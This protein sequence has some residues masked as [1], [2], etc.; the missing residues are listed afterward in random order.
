MSPQLPDGVRHVEIDLP[1]GRRE[2]VT[3]LVRALGLD[4]LLGLEAGA[5]GTG[6]DALA[7]ALSEL[8]AP[9]VLVLRDWQEMAWA[10]PEGWQQL[11]E[12]LDRR[13]TNR[14]ENWQGSIELPA[15]GVEPA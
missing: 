13:A 6:L 12:V 15:F 10:D 3:A 1:A 5:H 11:R 4:E 8:E 14:L 7:D 2:A 9:V